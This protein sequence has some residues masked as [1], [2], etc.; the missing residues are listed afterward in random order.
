M[1]NAET[2]VTLLDNSP[3]PPNRQASPFREG[4]KKGA[5]LGFRVALIIAAV[6]YPTGLVI[7]LGN[8]RV[9]AEELGTWK[10]IATFVG[11]AIGGFCL[12]AF[13]C[14]LTGALVAGVVNVFR[15]RQ[16]KSEI[17]NPQS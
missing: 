11:G 8:P 17:R 14:M 7:I 15:Y 9:R 16:S 13:Y 2:P 1:S 6:L 4:A 3:E 5:R 10:K 12:M